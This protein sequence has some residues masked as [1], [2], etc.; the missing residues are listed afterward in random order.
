ML[1]LIFL[2]IADDDF[3]KIE[4]VITTSNK[5]SSLKIS[6]KSLKVSLSTFWCFNCLICNKLIQFDLTEFFFLSW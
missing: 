1:L 2:G 4:I 5:I 6:L 3:V